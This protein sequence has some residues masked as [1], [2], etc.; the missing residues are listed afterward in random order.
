MFLFI[1][2]RL[3]RL[4]H[5]FCVVLSTP[6]KNRVTQRRWRFVFFWLRI[7]QC[8]YGSSILFIEFY[9]LGKHPFRIQMPFMQTK[10]QYAFS[11]CS[12]KF[13][14]IL[15]RFSAIEKW[16]RKQFEILCNSIRITIENLI[17]DITTKESL[18]FSL[19]LLLRQ[20][21]LLIISL[22]LMVFY[23]LCHFIMKIISSIKRSYWSKI[24]TKMAN[25]TLA[26]FPLCI[27]TFGKR[28]FPHIY[29]TKSIKCRPFYY[30]KKEPEMPMFV[31]LS[32]DKLCARKRERER[33]F[34]QPE[35]I[36]YSKRCFFSLRIHSNRVIISC[37][38]T[39]TGPRSI[40]YISRST[41][42]MNWTLWH[43]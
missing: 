25:S 30:H 42:F 23:C 3:K 33:E 4:H 43:T 41:Q 5:S 14:S 37:Y 12:L 36:W 18:L 10:P 11:V 6:R 27:F 38:E 15:H 13:K 24:G 17:I 29:R 19:L 39:Q 8:H 1:H 21:W 26:Y 16:V 9:L 28:C 20:L 2:A 7:Y 22:L 35:I 34:N 32:I 31:H 40:E